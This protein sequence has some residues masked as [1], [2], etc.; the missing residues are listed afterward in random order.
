MTPRQT[1]QFSEDQTDALAAPLEIGLVDL[2]TNDFT[3]FAGLGFG[4]V[5]GIAVDSLLGSYVPLRRTTSVLSSTIS[6][7]KPGSSSH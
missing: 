4:F 2:A 6:L 1:K 7:L 5:N 3:E